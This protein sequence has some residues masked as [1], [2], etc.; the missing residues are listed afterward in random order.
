MKKLKISKS[1]T[2]QY[3]CLSCRGE[4]TI[5]NISPPTPNSTGGWVTISPCDMCNESG[6]V[7]KTALQKQIKKGITEMTNLE[8]MEFCEEST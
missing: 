4:G 8:I 6:R 2:N 3:K 1:K 7:T 5:A